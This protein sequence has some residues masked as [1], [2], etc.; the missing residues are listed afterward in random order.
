MEIK[1]EN[2]E[3]GIQGMKGIKIKNLAFVQHPR[4]VDE[5]LLFFVFLRVSSWLSF[6]L[7][8]VL[9]TFGSLAAAQEPPTQVL[10]P[11][12]ASIDRLLS[13][14]YD[15]N[16]PGGVVLVEK[17]GKVVFRKAYG[18]ASVELNVP[19]QPER[20]FRI[21]SITK[22]ITAAAVLTLVED[23]QVDLKAPIGQYL[24][25]MPQAWGAVTVEQLLN[26]TGGIPNHTEVANYKAHMREDLAPGELLRTY[27]ASLPLD[28]ES[29]T[30]YRYSNTGYILLGML[31]EKVSAQPY[32]SFLQTRF[33]DPLGLKHI[34]YGSETE[35]IP[36]LV[37]GYTKGPK[38]CSYRSTSQTFASGGL[39]ATA[40]DVARWLQLL[41]EGKVLT[42]K[43]LARM[44][45][46]T[47][48]KNGQ[49]VGYGFGIGFRPIGK[50]RLAGH[51]GGVPGYKSWAEA[52]PVT[53]TF[54]VILNNTDAPKGDD[55]DYAK[56]I[57][58]LL[59]GVPLQEP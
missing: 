1:D 21:G 19:M 24:E 35:L 38:P 34:R 20:V 14:R 31:I 39:V 7:I 52:D 56:S 42:P 49:E 55:A 22:Q 54:V 40:D 12:A 25:G 46:P 8:P 36:G 30:A 51:A 47:K 59:A 9:L 16:Q 45:A 58:S 10:S 15:A 41:Y 5:S 4:K 33:F 50:A 37:P 13:R 6:S 57:F 11:Q 2:I 32:P 29:G 17:G 27:V 53:R 18:L 44:L 48:L 26:H 23:G 28:F 43:S 3:T